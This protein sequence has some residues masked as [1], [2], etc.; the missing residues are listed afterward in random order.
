MTENKPQPTHN[1]GN[2]EMLSKH[3]QDTPSIKYKHLN[4]N[5]L[6]TSWTTEPYQRL[7][8]FLQSL[9]HGSVITESWLNRL[10][11]HYIPNFEEAVLK[12]EYKMLNKENQ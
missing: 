12:Y 7:K 11:N 9:E 2:T 5:L 8:G 1:N 4:T 3:T 10:W 6:D